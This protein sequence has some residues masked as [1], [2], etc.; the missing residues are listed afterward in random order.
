MVLMYMETDDDS[1]ELLAAAYYARNASYGKRKTYT[2]WG[3][4]NATKINRPTIIKS[5]SA[6]LPGVFKYMPFKKKCIQIHKSLLNLFTNI[7]FLMINEYME[8]N[9]I[10]TISECTCT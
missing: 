5:C 10:K 1:E 7:I 8:T 4:Q 9:I 3:P 2:M 6:H